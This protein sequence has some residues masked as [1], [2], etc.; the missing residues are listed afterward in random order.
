M[1][2][3]ERCVADSLEK[4]WP[5]DP[6]SI[7]IQPVKEHDSVWIPDGEAARCMTCGSTQFNLY[8]EE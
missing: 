7:V 2:H 3:M 8:K 5:S 4:G 1:I 6:T